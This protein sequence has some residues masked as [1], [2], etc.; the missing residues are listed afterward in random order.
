MKTR[1]KGVVPQSVTG[2]GVVAGGRVLQDYG[3]I[4]HIF[5]TTISL[6]MIVALSNPFPVRNPFPGGSASNYRHL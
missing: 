5:A 2:Q 6:G 3:S 1:P 4:V